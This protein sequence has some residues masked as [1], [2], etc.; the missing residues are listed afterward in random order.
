MEGESW[1]RREGRGE[2]GKGRWGEW[3]KGDFSDIQAPLFR[4]VHHIY[5]HS[6]GF[7]VFGK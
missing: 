7:F 2:W 5:K 3:G 1:R 6:D 4:M